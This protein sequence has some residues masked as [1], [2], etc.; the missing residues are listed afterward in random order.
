MTVL[1]TYDTAFFVVNVGARNRAN[2]LVFI[3]F[4]VVQVF[5]LHN[6]LLAAVRRNEGRRAR[7]GLR[8]Q[9]AP[10]PPPR[11]ESGRALTRSRARA[12]VCYVSLWNILAR[13]KT[14]LPL[15]R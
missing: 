10:P 4:L 7:S 2:V 12:C 6:I 1:G 13:F 8:A 5:L 15:W 14:A 9:R 11:C 3:S